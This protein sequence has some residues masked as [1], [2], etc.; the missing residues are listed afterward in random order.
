MVTCLVASTGNSGW[1]RR[2][3]GEAAFD[4][5]AAEALAGDGREQRVGRGAGAFGE[6]GLEDSTVWRDERCA[7]FLAA[8]ADGVHVGAGGER[9][10]GAGEAGQSEI[11]R[12]VWIVSASMGV[13]ARPVQV[14]WSQA[15]RRASTSGSVRKVTRFLSN[16]LGGIASTR[17]IER[18]VFGVVQ[19]DVANSEWMAARR[20]LRVRDAV[21]ALAF[22]VVQ[23]GGDQRRVE[24]GDVELAGRLGGA[25]GGEGEQQPE[26]VAVGGDGVRAGCALTDQPVGEEGLQAGASAVIVGLRSGACSRSAASAISSGVA[27]RYQYV[28]LG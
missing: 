9:D 1:R 25:L 18:G 13:V 10:V 15:A 23:E 3:C 2:R 14:V 24:M 11:R 7:P 27:D 4:R 20:S 5:V 26:G 21:A 19:R 28:P 22:E 12:P 6:P 8:F 16:R 17:W